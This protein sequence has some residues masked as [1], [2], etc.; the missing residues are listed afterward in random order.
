MLAEAR[1]GIKKVSK[2]LAQREAVIETGRD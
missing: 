1:S 2:R